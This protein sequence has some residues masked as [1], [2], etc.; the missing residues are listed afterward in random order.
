MD[1]GLQQAF[2]YLA[3][4]VLAAPIAAR[5]GLGSVLGYLIAGAAIGPWALNLVGETE[6]VS[7]VAEFGVVILLFLIGLDGD[8]GSV[9]PSGR[10]NL[11]GRCPAPARPVIPEFG[12]LRSIYP[13]AIQTTI[14]IVSP[15]ARSSDTTMRG[16]R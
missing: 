13:R 1:V 3:A 9:A 6:R 16:L 4:G 8:P 7:H 10:Q 5:I 14:H 15:A 11:I 12:V 2:V